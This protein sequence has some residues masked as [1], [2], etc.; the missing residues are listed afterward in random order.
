MV[1]VFGCFHAL[2][3]LVRAP[4][5]SGDPVDPSGHGPGLNLT[6]MTG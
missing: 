5:S 4:Y 2:E 3:L 1:W 6:L